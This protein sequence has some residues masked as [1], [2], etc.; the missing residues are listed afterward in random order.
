M[1]RE[2]G[3]EGPRSRHPDAEARR[4]TRALSPRGRGKPT[5]TRTPAPR[6]AW[7]QPRSPPPSASAWTPFSPSW[8]PSSPPRGPSPF[9]PSCPS[10]PSEETPGLPERRT[11]QSREAARRK[12]AL[13]GVGAG[14]RRAETR[15]F[16]PARRPGF[17]TVGPGDGRRAGRLLGPPRRVDPGEGSAPRARGPQAA[18]CALGFRRSSL[19][20]GRPRVGR[21][22]SERPLSA[23]LGRVAGKWSGSTTRSG[24]PVRSP[25]RAQPAG[26]ASEL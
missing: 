24:G 25:R 26:L 3:G 6:T 10:R 4:C 2:L 13:A 22:R 15:H 11:A 12:Y 8:R 17:R 14:S 18:R 23:L 1:R 16:R 5:G 20:A 19:S 9:C 21:G 7:R